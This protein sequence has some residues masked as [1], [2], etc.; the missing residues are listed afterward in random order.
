MP[1]LSARKG[2]AYFLS[3]LVFLPAR[4]QLENEG[5][6]VALSCR[7]TCVINPWMY[8]VGLLWLAQRL[9]AHSCL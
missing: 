4:L 5:Q 1:L 7:L 2:N 3:S 9:V 8:F 6:T